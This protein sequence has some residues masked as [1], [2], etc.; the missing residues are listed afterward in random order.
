VASSQYVLTGRLLFY[1]HCLG[2]LIVLSIAVEIA[3][4]GVVVAVNEPDRGMAK[5]WPQDQ[6]QGK[7]YEDR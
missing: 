4:I 2:E 1:G 3:V 7:L 5:D 6:V